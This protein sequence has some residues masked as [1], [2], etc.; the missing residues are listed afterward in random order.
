MQTIRAEIRKLA[1]EY[2]RAHPPPDAEAF[3]TN[4]GDHRGDPFE[5]LPLVSGR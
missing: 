3:E 2:T 5:R 4:L 1:Q